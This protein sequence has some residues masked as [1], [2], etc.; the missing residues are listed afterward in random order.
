MNKNDNFDHLIYKINSMNSSFDIAENFLNSIQNQKDR[1]I[2][3][4]NLEIVGGI[5]CQR[6]EEIIRIGKDG[7]VFI[8]ISDNLYKI[9]EEI[10]GKIDKVRINQLHSYFIDFIISYKL[11]EKYTFLPDSLKGHLTINSEVGNGVFIFDGYEFLQ[12]SYSKTTND[13]LS[14]LCKYINR[15]KSE[16]K[17]NHESSSKY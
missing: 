5:P 6:Y 1:K 7:D 2:D 13:S 11:S 8:K 12:K 9:H 3:A 4:I 14:I 17:K 10:L 16:I 15:I